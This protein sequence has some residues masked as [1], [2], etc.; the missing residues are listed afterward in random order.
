MIDYIASPALGSEA[1]S[2]GCA[3]SAIEADFAGRNLAMGLSVGVNRTLELTV[4]A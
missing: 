1:A 4:A 2:A 3:K